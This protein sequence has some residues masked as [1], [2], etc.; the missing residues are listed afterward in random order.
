MSSQTNDK[1]SKNTTHPR[2]TN[3]ASKE[4]NRRYKQQTTSSDDKPL[5]NTEPSSVEVHK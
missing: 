3:P 1:H 5:R 2:P 4:Q